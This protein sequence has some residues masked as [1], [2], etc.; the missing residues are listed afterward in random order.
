VAPRT[1]DSRPSQPPR[2]LLDATT[3]VFLRYGFRKT[4][5]DDLARAAGL[6]RQGLY[7][8]FASKELIFQAVLRHIVAQTLA[9]VHAVVD[10]RQPG[11]EER[12]L[13]AFEALHGYGFATASLAHMNELV[14]TA[15]ALEG[16]LV[17]ELEKSFIHLVAGLLVE[18]GVAERWALKGVSA[19]QLAELLFAAGSGIKASVAAPAAYRSRMRVAVKVILVGA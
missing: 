8:Q 11:L 6:S 1:K 16:D 4:T 5:M 2:A 14:E 17:A 10:Q 3:G 7:L 13:G 12:L 18:E 19:K 15:R 9:A